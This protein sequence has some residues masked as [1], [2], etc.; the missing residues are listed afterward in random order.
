MSFINWLITSSSDPRKTSLF[1]KGL[2][3]FG[4]AWVVRAVDTACTWGVVCLG[5]D[6]AIVNNV[7]EAVEGVI[8]AGML[9]VGS[10]VALVGI[11][12]KFIV[13]RWSHPAA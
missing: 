6:S 1:V 9:L 4:G 7:A 3:L 11:V 8:F 13:G 2:I 5:I 12:R 10:I